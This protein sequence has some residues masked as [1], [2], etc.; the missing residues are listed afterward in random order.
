[1]AR[2]GSH[3]ETPAKESGILLKLK[4]LNGD[5]A[6]ILSNHTIS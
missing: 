6:F 2:P 3:R 1:M 4:F 5:R